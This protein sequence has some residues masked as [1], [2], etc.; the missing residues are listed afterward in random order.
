MERRQLREDKRGI[1]LQF[2]NNI[3]ITR[4]KWLGKQKKK[5]EICLG[6]STSDHRYLDSSLQR[7]YKWK[8]N[9][10]TYSYPPEPEIFM[11]DGELSPPPVV[12]YQN[13]DPSTTLEDYYDMNSDE[14][15]QK[16][17]LRF[18]KRKIKEMSEFMKH[19]E[20]IVKLNKRVHPSMRGYKDAIKILDSRI[21]QKDN[22]LQHKMSLYETKLLLEEN[23]IN[24]EKAL[25]DIKRYNYRIQRIQE[26]LD[27]EVPR[28][29]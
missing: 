2:L 22:Q 13:K 19:D 1:L 12:H 18:R 26:E 24:Y 5:M 3:N 23:M 6:G 10:N 28:I 21:K 7:L 14:R 9:R 29:Y 25:S 16:K 20:N 17:L 4:D 11:N 27:D 8:N 15:I